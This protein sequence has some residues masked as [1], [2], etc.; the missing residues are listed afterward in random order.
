MKKLFLIAVSGLLLSG[1]YHTV[2]TAPAGITEPVVEE[3]AMEET[4][5]VTEK[6]AENMV[7]YGDSGFAPS[8]I[9]VKVGT[10]VTW[11]ND[12]NKM[13]WVASAVHPTHQELPGFDQLQAVGNG[14]SY[15]Y[16]FTGAGTW[17]Y[18][19]HVAA[20]DTGMVVVEE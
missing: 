17:K 11:K 9:T 5:V 3:E 13:M 15:S 10:E 14:G 4:P 12:G 20:G 6:A 2:T 18:H 7:T 8:T 1:C 16:T 19:N